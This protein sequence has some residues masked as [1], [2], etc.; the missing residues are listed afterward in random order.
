MEGRGVHQTGMQR[1]GRHNGARQLGEA[2]GAYACVVLERYRS[3]TSYCIG[4]KGCCESRGQ[5]RYVGVGSPRWKR[6]GCISSTCRL[7]EPQTCRREWS[8]CGRGTTEQRRGGGRHTLDK[9]QAR[10]E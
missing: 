5:K 3:R 2:I 10:G 8:M 7:P 1:T 6:C 9:E 4:H